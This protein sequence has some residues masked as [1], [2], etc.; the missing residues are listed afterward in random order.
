MTL[1]SPFY[2]EVANIIL[3]DGYLT[4]SLGRNEM[5]MTIHR[6]RGNTK[7]KLLFGTGNQAKLSAMKS[8]LEKIGI[9]FMSF[10]KMR[11]KTTK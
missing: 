3:L 9:D 10:D 5:G 7:M 6:L 8:R 2:R 4:D 1:T 11:H